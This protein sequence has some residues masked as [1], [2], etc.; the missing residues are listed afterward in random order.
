MQ[1]IQEGSVVTVTG[2]LSMRKPKDQ[3]GKWELQLI[4]RKI[5]PGDEA[6]APKG[7][8]QHRGERAPAPPPDD[9][10]DLIF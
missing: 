1:G 6:K 2:D 4:A 3:G 7:R 9:T 5:V 10:D 8:A